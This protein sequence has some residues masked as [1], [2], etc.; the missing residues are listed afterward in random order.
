[1]KSKSLLFMLSVV[2]LLLMACGG[3]KQ[4]TTGENPNATAGALPCPSWFYTIP[5]H[6]DTLFDVA[7]ATSKD[8][9]LAIDKAT[10]DA[11]AKIG[12]QVETRMKAMGQR[13]RT[14]V[15]EGAESQLSSV[16]ERVV[17]D[18]VNVTLSGSKV[19]K[20]SITQESGVWRSCVLV[21]Y[22][23]GA[24]NAAFVE[25]LKREQI[26]R[27]RQDLQDAVQRMNAELEKNE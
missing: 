23:V 15:G 9:Q 21:G 5:S 2:C 16:I 20:Q 10:M 4:M 7:T 8:L 18:L 26:V 25:N 6:K 3:A 24:A 12:G 19:I 11:R 27:A 22:P 1:M 17:Q 14:E 13:L